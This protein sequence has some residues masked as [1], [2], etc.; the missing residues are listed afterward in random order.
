[1]TDNNSE[2]VEQ[3]VVG[4]GR[5][6]RD[7]DPLRG[8]YHAGGQQPEESG[9]TDPET[10]QAKRGAKRHEKQNVGNRDDQE[11][12]V[13]LEHFADLA[14]RPEP[15]LAPA[16]HREQG[17]DS[18][19]G[20]GRSEHHV[21]EGCD[22]RPPFDRNDRLDAETIA[23]SAVVRPDAREYG[24]LS[25]H[26]SSRSAMSSSSVSGRL[27]VPDPASSTGTTLSTKRG[28][29]TGCPLRISPFCRYFAAPRVGLEPTTLRLTAG[30]SAN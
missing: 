12:R 2:G 17:H 22:R 7:E 18:D 20:H 19:G 4:G 14:E 9:G 1:M 28:H 5:T 30:C 21:R 15:N 26:F 8:F 24:S 13:G 23:S 10:A 3:N 11:P 27:Q 6:P 16:L 25:R 29:L